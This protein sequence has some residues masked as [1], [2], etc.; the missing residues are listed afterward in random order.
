MLPLLWLALP[1]IGVPVRPAVAQDPGAPPVADTLATVRV[2][3][4]HEGDPVEGALV[5]SERV[6]APTD[7]RGT[8]VLRLVAGPHR[9]VTSR[10]GLAP[11]TVRVVLRAG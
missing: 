7:A 9:V 6:G 10:L 11:D 1:F 4:T 3:V 5:R 2:T 8:A